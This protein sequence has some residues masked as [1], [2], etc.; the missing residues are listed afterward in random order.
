MLLSPA[1]V[2]GQDRSKEAALLVEI[3]QGFY[4]PRGGPELYLATAQ[5]VPQ[6]SL[7]PGR[8]RV[9]LP[10]GLFHPGY[11][12]GGL[13]GSRLTLNV[14]QG[15]P[16][17]LASS[18]QLHILAEYLPLVYSP[19]MHWRQ[20]VGAGVGLET[21]NLLGITLKLHRDVRTPAIYGQLMLTYNLFHQAPPPL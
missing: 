2:M 7:V 6:W 14:L 16:V 1:S 9:G 17:L 11:Q 10:V 5:A 21:S 19:T 12:L 8:L 13:A 4:R 20:L 18:F 15:A 3:G